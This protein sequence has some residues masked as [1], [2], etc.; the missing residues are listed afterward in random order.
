MLEGGFT[1]QGGASPG[2]AV[3]SVLDGAIEGGFRTPPVRWLMLAAPFTAGVGF[4][5]FY[6][7][8]PYLLQL[9]GD[10]NAYGIAGLAAAIAAGAPNVRRLAPG[11]GRR[12]VS[13]RAPAP[14]SGA[15]PHVGAPL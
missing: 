14:P 13:R 15:P 1:P 7:F 9:Y 10:P 6:A 11:S 12:G 3:R 2:K 8:Q 4:Y 5:A